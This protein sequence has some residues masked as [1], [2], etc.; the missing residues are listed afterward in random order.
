MATSTYVGSKQQKY[1]EN[2]KDKIL[3]KKHAK[4]EANKIA[5]ENAKA[6]QAILLQKTIEKINERGT[7]IYATILD[8]DFKKDTRGV[9][10]LL[11]D[12]I[13]TQYDLGGMSNLKILIDYMA[14]NDTP[15]N[16]R[17]YPWNLI[18]KTYG[19]SLKVTINQR[20]RYYNK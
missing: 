12:I 4:T 14:L 1:Y 18:E 10:D 5:K 6:E 9:I 8:E 11:N 16:K 17:A 20:K 19:L 3:A 2:N 7:N 15:F 13:P